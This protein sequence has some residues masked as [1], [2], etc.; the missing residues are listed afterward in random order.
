MS[1]TVI[2]SFT[3]DPSNIAAFEA[4]LKVL[5]EATRREPGC[6]QYDV[7]A[8]TDTDGA[9][10]IVEQYATE[11]D[12]LFHREQQHIL[13]FRQIAAPLFK[14]PPVVLRGVQAW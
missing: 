1:F 5:T 3:I 4:G 9:Y 13:D 6:V 14:E 12:Y 2:A 11:S 8:S 10:F 7:I